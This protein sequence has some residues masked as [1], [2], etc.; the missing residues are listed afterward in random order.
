MCI[1]LLLFHF[2]AKFTVKKSEEEEDATKDTYV[3]EC[4]GIGMANP[5]L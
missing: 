4:E 1:H 2:Q 5:H 3:I